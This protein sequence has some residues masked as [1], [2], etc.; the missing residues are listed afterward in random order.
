MRAHALYLLGAELRSPL[1]DVEDR[2]ALLAVVSEAQQGEQALQ[3][4][5]SGAAVMAPGALAING[6]GQ[7]VLGPL[8]VDPSFGDAGSLPSPQYTA[9]DAE[10]RW[11][12]KPAGSWNLQISAPRSTRTTRESARTRV[13]APTAAPTAA[14]P[15]LVADAGT[16]APAFDAL[17]PS[18]VR[19]PTTRSRSRA[20][21]T[22]RRTAFGRP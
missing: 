4:S 18:T 11:F 2:D 5:N 7:V 15:T 16:V 14:P 12:R 13:A 22:A 9:P 17:E 21:A 20:A 19:G 3:R 6:M 8:R 10:T 1:V